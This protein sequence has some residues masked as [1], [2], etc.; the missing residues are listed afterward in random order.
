MCDYI[1]LS[2]NF[3]TRCARTDRGENTCKSHLVQR[4]EDLTPESRPGILSEFMFRHQLGRLNMVLLSELPALTS[5][6]RI[7][8]VAVIK[9]HVLTSPWRAEHVAAIRSYV[10]TPT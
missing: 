6:W 8:D 7:K 10:L 5:A 1:K 9:T 2:V 4:E 3:W